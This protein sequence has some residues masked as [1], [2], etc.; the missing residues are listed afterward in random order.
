MGT[1]GRKGLK[2]YSYLEVEGYGR[3]I[4]LLLVLEGRGGHL[5]THHVFHVTLELLDSPHDGVGLGLILGFACA[6]RIDFDVCGVWRDWDLADHIRREVSALKDRLKFHTI[7]QLVEVWVLLDY[8]DN[9]ERQ[10][11]IF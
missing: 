8:W 10:I 2:G 11:D 7:F 9:L 5:S 6:S 3:A 4:P 1:Y